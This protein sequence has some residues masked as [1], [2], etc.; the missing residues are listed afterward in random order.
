VEEQEGLIVDKYLPA[1]VRKFCYIFAVIIAV[2]DFIIKSTIP[3]YSL[4]SGISFG[5]LEANNFW[6]VFYLCLLIL[7]LV[8]FARHANLL[9]RFV[10]SILLILSVS[11]VI[12]R[13]MFGGV[14]DYI[15]AFGI[16]FNLSDLGINLFVL[17]MIY[18]FII[19]DAQIHSRS[20][21]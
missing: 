15:V 3:N 21:K 1:R 18:I 20:T 7:N 6:I 12:D 14:R 16:T 17:V 10:L 8:Q 5:L 9:M 2:G 13:L 19:H 11:N 4:N